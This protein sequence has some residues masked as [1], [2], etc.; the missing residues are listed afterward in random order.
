MER[1]KY[2]LCEQNF[3]TKNILY[4]SIPMQTFFLYFDKKKKVCGKHLLE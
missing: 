4:F 1:R 3:V 2:L